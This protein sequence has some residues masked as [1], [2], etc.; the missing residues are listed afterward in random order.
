VIKVNIDFKSSLSKIKNIE[1]RNAA[2]NKLTD[3]EKRL[4]IAWDALNLVLSE[5]VSPSYGEYWS[6]N[7]WNIKY[8][9]KDSKELQINLNNL[10][11]EVYCAVCARGLCMVSQI[12][13]G[14]N[15]DPDN[16]GVIS[17]SEDT[18][19]GFSMESFRNMEDEFESVF[20]SHPYRTNTRE[21]LANMMCNVLVNGDFDIHDRSDYL[22][23]T[24]E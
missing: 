8:S 2:F 20:F 21:K 24:E 7:L 11:K 9:S 19:N 12:R 17:G 3:E 14:N 5:T 1:E 4:E 23:I 13:L 15:I 6:N 10:K 16:G 22:I 18:L